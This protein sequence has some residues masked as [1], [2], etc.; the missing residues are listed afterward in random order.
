M[1]TALRFFT[2]YLCVKD[3]SKLEFYGKKL[4]A[5]LF[6][7]G[8]TNKKRFFN[9]LFLVLITMMMMIMMIIIIIIIIILILLH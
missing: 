4:D 5:S 2:V 9:H 3:S 7:F 8:S 6:V 1:Q